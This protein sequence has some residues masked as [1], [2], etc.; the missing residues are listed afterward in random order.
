MDDLPSSPEF[1]RARQHHNVSESAGL[2]AADDSLPSSPYWA[3]RNASKSP[4]ISSGSSDRSLLQSSSP[5]RRSKSY[6]KSSPQEKP[7]YRANSTQSLQSSAKRDDLQEDSDPGSDQ[8]D[9]TITTDGLKNGS[10]KQRYFSTETVTATDVDNA[11]SK[12]KK[13]DD[14]SIWQAVEDLRS[15]VTKLELSDRERKSNATIIESAISSSTTSIDLLSSPDRTSTGTPSTSSTNHRRL[16]TAL[17]SARE[18]VPADVYRCLVT[19]LSDIENL[20]NKLPA[21]RTVRLKMEALYRSL[22]DL[23]MTLCENTVFMEDHNISRP[24]SR[25][26]QQGRS[27]PSIAIRSDPNPVLDSE[28]GITSRLPVRAASR[29]RNSL[30]MNQLLRPESRLAIKGDTVPSNEYGHTAAEFDWSSNINRR[31]TIAGT[32]AMA[33]V[34]PT[35]RVAMQPSLYARDKVAYRPQSMIGVEVTGRQSGMIMSS[36]PN[37]FR[38]S[39]RV[40]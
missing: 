30:E 13:H 6:L 26:Q 8:E 10:L 29:M 28:N 20:A 11:R 40:D 38:G 2:P 18:T 12:G 19:T 34:R 33:A 32:V 3:L 27:T 31:R 35:S 16:L 25:Q 4:I 21:G 22:A 36:P 1:L 24:Y 23:S 14:E 37:I 7:L 17:T 39:D 5:L 9:R 15:R